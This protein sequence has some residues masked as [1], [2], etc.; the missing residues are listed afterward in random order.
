M[1]VGGHWLA[2]CNE[3]LRDSLQFHHSR[4]CSRGAPDPM[5]TNKSKYQEL[6]QGLFAIGPSPGRHFRVLPYLYVATNWLCVAALMR[7]PLKNLSEVFIFVF[8]P[9]PLHNRRAHPSVH[10]V[11]KR[12][13][14][15]C[16]W[17]PPT[18]TTPPPT[19]RSIKMIFLNASAIS[20]VS[21]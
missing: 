1:G 6:I 20:A 3:L 4:N 14:C 16:D 2:P 13:H 15:S 9:V 21:D 8:F 19:E 18:T 5:K 12:L 17:T 7:K 11:V 10:L